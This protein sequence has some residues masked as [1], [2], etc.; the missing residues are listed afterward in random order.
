MAITYGFFNSLN[1]DRVYNADQMSDMFEGL[2]KGGVYESV[3][4]AFIV[5][6]SSGLTLSVGSGRAIVGGKW[7]KSDAD[8][9]LTLNSAHVTLN[10]YTAIV[11]RKSVSNRTVTIEMIDGTPAST[12][13]KPSITRDNLV[14]EICL[15]YVY[16]PAGATSITASNIEDMRTN[17]NVCGFVTGLITQVNT[18]ELFNQ[19]K[20]AADE[21]LEEMESW[22]AS[23][24]AAFD[25]WLADLTQE[26]NVDTYIRPYYQ[27]STLTNNTLTVNITGYSYE[28][29]DII[30]VFI[31]GLR[32]I[33]GTDYSVNTSGTSPVITFN[34]TNPSGQ[35]IDIQ[36]LK[37][38]IGFST[39]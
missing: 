24:K 7:I 19:Y 28:S 30:N 18:T 9:A 16:V 4:N 29:G 31:N 36:I 33:E 35:Q 6:P 27:S 23:Q 21:N 10:R 11:L 1:G 13:T 34:F 22:E 17:T 3:G 5:R 25:A 14:Y 20:A 2:I 26:L 8:I 39:N 37:S 15:A 32:G 12:P 38:V